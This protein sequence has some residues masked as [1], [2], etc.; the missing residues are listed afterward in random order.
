MRHT[1]LPLLLLFILCSTLAHAQIR[2]KGQLIRLEST[3]TVISPQDIAPPASVS[4]IYRNLPGDGTV[5]R[6]RGNYGVAVRDRLVVGGTGAFNTSLGNGGG[7]SDVR[8]A[9][10]VRYYPVESDQLQG[11]GQVS[12]DIAYDAAQFTALETVTA[13]VGI[14]YDLGNNQLL[15]PTLNY[16]VGEGPNTFG[17]GVGI[18]TYLTPPGIVVSPIDTLEP[19]DWMLGGQVASF[20]SSEFRNDVNVQLGGH[21]FTSSRFAVAGQAGIARQSYDLGGGNYVWR[22][23]NLAVG[24]RYYLNEGQQRLWFV[25][26]GVGRVWTGDGSSGDGG[27]DRNFS[28]LTGGAGVQ[29]FAAGNLAVEAGPQLRFRL[30][31]NTLVPGLNFGVRGI[32]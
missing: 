23:L 21:Y 31:D 28:Y 13:T 7:G 9:P 15:T 16:R 3:H 14:Q 19:G 22:D 18:E 25:D 24:G 17:F 27:D 30:D 6:L 2:R 10:Y 29:C 12:T 20:R 32:R 8:V 5:I 26:A 4:S 11:F 1:Y